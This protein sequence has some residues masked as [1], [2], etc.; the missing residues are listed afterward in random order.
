V[1]EANTAR[2][3]DNEDTVEGALLSA[4]QL[5]RLAFEV[6]TPE[7]KPAAR[8]AYRLALKAFTDHVLRQRSLW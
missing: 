5:T 1:V 8:D 4:V 7:T 3:P 6:A 2:F